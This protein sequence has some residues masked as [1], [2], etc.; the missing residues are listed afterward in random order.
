M[1]V[2]SVRMHA[3]GNQVSLCCALRESGCIIIFYGN[4]TQKHIVVS[5]IVVKVAH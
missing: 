1:Y 3:S 4:I 2:Y 5:G